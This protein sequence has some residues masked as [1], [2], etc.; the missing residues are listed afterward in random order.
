[1]S[2]E[3]PRTKRGGTN[4]FA[5]R[6]SALALAAILSV[7]VAACGSSSSS[8]S[9]AGDPGSGGSSA[10]SSAVTNVT[11]ASAGGIK[12]G[13]FIWDLYAALSNGYFTKQHVKVSVV[14]VTDGSQAVQAMTSG[15]ADAGDVSADAFVDGINAGAP[16][17]IGGFTSLGQDQLIVLKNITAW[18]QLNGAKIGTSTSALGGTDIFLVDMLKAH[19]ISSSAV[20]FETLGAS[21]AKVQALATGAIDGTLLSEPYSSDATEGGKAHALASTW[22]D[23]ST[24][25]P[26]IAVGFSKSFVSAHPAAAKGVITAFQQAHDWLLQPSN[27]SKAVAMLVHYTGV[28]QAAAQ[29]TYNV[30]FKQAHSLIPKVTATSAQVQAL[31]KGMGKP[32][33]AADAAKYIETS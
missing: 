10:S 28:T 25:W 6:C 19:G 16:V 22:D 8:K 5:A 33:T 24:K 32:S 30:E 9:S 4:K 2:I 21:P 29:A 26:F 11:M 1:M 31:L 18:S 13:A 20:H 23:A 12:Q 15:A 3:D 27:E 14:T 17:Q 7:S